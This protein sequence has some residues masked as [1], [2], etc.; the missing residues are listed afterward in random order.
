MAK[1][2]EVIVGCDLLS[3]LYFCSILNSRRFRRGRVHPVVICFQ[4]CIFV[5]F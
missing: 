5:V 2:T 1:D 4:I 3:N